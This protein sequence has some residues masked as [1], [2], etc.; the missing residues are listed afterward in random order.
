MS[1]KSIEKYGIYY[2]EEKLLLIYTF[3]K[4][5]YIRTENNSV[6]KKIDIEKEAYYYC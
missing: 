1:E 2:N 6:Y 5:A 3:K 4:I